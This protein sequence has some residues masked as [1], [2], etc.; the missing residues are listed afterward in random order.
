MRLTAWRLMFAVAGG[1]NIIVACVTA[2][3]QPS[4]RYRL[5][6]KQYDL[7]QSSLK[8]FYAINKSKYSETWPVSI[9]NFGMI[10]YRISTLFSTFCG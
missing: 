1:C 7:A 3:V 5:F 2:L 4:P 8:L 9:S 10:F 6:R